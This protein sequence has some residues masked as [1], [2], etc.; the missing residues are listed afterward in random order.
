MWHKPLRPLHDL[1][2]RISEQLGKGV[3]L[4]LRHPLTIPAL[5]FLTHSSHHFKVVSCET[6]QRRPLVTR[7]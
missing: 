5:A 2:E 4:T 7:R 1:S 3:R 6:I